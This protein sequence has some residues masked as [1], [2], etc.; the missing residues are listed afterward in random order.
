ME[1]TFSGTTFR[2]HSVPIL[3]AKTAG[4]AKN[5]LRF[6]IQNLGMYEFGKQHGSKVQHWDDPSKKKHESM[7]AAVFNMSLAIAICE[8]FNILLMFILKWFPYVPSYLV[9]TSHLVL[10]WRSPNDTTDGWFDQPSV[11]TPTPRSELSDGLRHLPRSS[12]HVCQ[13]GPGALVLGW[14]RRVY[15]VWTLLS[16]IFF[17]IFQRCSKKN[18]NKFCHT[19]PRFPWAIFPNK[20]LHHFLNIF[21]KL[22]PIHQTLSE[23]Y[24]QHFPPSSSPNSNIFLTIS[25]TFPVMNHPN[26]PQMSGPHNFSKHFFVRTISPPSSPC[27]EDHPRNWLLGLSQVITREMGEP[28]RNRERIWPGKLTTYN[29]M[30]LQVPSPDAR[31]WIWNR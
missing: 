5:W 14:D 10:V 2:Y 6:G 9:T 21:P 22:C 19:I 24:P 28:T 13:T 30:I 7:I 1:W 27:L 15:Q 26:H 17:W 23:S 11:S 25:P 31:R 3:A 4:W 16:W 18:I 8:C 29:W 12:H 20:F